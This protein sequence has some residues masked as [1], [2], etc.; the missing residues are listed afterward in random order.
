MLIFIFLIGHTSTS[1]VQEW[2]V[3]INISVGLQLFL[4]DI[5]LLSF[6]LAFKIHHNQ[7]SFFK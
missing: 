4:M 3:R 6:N 7:L 1:S 5:V 2:N